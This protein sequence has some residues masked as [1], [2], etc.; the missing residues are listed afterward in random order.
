MYVAENPFHADCLKLLRLMRASGGQA[1]RRDLMRSMHIKSQ[2]FD[3]LANT[4]LLQ[5]DIMRV[6]VPTKTKPT[7]GYRLAS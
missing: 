5:Q 4:L 1:A 3:Q 6:E 2:D 7:Q